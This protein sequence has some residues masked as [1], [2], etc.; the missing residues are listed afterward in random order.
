MCKRIRRVVIRMTLW[1]MT[2]ISIR[3]SRHMFSIVLSY[4]APREPIIYQERALQATAQT[5]F[6]AVLTSQSR[7]QVTNRTVWPVIRLIVC[8]TSSP[9]A[10]RIAISHPT[11]QLAQQKWF[12]KKCKNRTHTCSKVQHSSLRLTITSQRLQ[13]LLW[14]AENLHQARRDQVLLKGHHVM[15]NTNN[16]IKGW[17]ANP[18]ILAPTLFK[19]KRVPSRLLHRTTPCS[20]KMILISLFRVKVPTIIILWWW[21]IRVA[22]V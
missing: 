18:N 4:K 21:V 11:I 20:I 14:V 2:A 12:S 9:L 22:R 13:L 7:I 6:K 19:L 17:H 10:N 5:I 1:V 16:R 8:S 3:S 15:I